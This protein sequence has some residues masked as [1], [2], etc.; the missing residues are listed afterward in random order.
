MQYYTKGDANQNQDESYRE[1]KDIIG[2]VKF[3]IPQIGQ[4]TLFINELFEK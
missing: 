4:L 1:E 2:I 3:R